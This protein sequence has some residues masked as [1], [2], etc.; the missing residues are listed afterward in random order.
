[1]KHT[2]RLTFVAGSLAVAPFSAI[3]IAQTEA[4]RQPERLVGQRVI[5][6][7][8]ALL[9]LTS[10]QRVKVKAILVAEEPNIIA[11]HAQAEEERE[12]MAALTTY[13]ESTLRQI[14]QKYDSTK[15]E[16]RRRAFQDPS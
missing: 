5:A 6:R 10:D 4:P 14:A 2:R 12:A 15:Y 8:E 13:D 16:H 3:A 7:V 1:M 9:K 11:L